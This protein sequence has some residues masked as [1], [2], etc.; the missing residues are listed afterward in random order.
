MVKEEQL[1]CNVL[2]VKC[3]LWNHLTRQTY[4]WNQ[5]ELRISGSLHFKDELVK[6]IGPF[7]TSLNMS[8]Y[9][10]NNSGTIARLLEEGPAWLVVLCSMFFTANA[11]D[12]MLTAIQANLILAR[13]EAPITARHICMFWIVDRRGCLRR[14]SSLICT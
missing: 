3:N 9:K 14:S 4:G 7:L 13:T 6:E 11:A 10:P 5:G 2:M 12:P 8:S 1:L